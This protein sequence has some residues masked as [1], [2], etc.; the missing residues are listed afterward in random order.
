MPETFPTNSQTCLLKCIVILNDKDITLNAYE[1]TELTIPDV[2]I[3]TFDAM[4]LVFQVKH[5]LTDAFK[6]WRVIDN[7]IYTQNSTKSI[8]ILAQKTCTIKANEPICHV[9]LYS[10]SEVITKLRGNNFN[11]YQDF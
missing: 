1:L 4:Q 10:V 3:D 2:K 5:H 9:Q 11:F 8:T 7:F 6:F